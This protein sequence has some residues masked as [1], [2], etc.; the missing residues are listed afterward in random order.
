MAPEP[1]TD[2]IR[3]DPSVSPI[4]IWLMVAITK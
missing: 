2:S 1:R 4:W 3:N